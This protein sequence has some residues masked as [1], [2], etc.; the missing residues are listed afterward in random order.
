MRRLVALAVLAVSVASV[1][2]QQDSAPDQTAV[3]VEQEP[4]HRL[5]FANDF[6]RIIDALLPSLYVS[7]KHTHTF[8]NVAVTILG[9]GDTPQARAR[10]GFA[11]FSRGGYTHVITNPN[12]GP[13]R[14]IDVELRSANPGESSDEPPQT[15]HEIVL[16]NQRVRVTRVKLEPAEK[17]DAHFHAAG[18]V[19]V[20]VRG[21]EAAGTWRWHAASE[22]PA[23]LS[24]GRQA[25]E[26]VEIEPR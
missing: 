21:L 2:A 4:R 15:G 16:F 19:S 10:V 13:M 25:L 20:V 5:V 26:L 22:A 14:F 7:Q 12:P 18:Y 9:G 24:A 11:G 8:D 6:V 17:I 3:P 1:A 23:G